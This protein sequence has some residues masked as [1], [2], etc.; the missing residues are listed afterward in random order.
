MLAQHGAAP[1][2]G[3]ESSYSN[4]G[5]D[6]GGEGGSYSIDQLPGDEWLVSQHGLRVKINQ[7]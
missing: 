5:F 6:E 7:F 2:R 3:L 4:G 1:C